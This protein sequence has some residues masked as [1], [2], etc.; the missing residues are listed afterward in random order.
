[1]ES[2]LAWIRPVVK[3]SFQIV[4]RH[5]RL[6]AALLKKEAS[7]SHLDQAVLVPLRMALNESTHGVI[8]I[9]RQLVFHT[10]VSRHGIRSGQ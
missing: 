9:L 8:K 7:D 6:L 4:L 1:M 10:D 2:H 5:H 3:K